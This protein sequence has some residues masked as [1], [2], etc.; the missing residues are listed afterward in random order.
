MRLCGQ[1]L[2][3]DN[4]AVHVLGADS[5]LGAGAAR[6]T[7]LP[8]AN[9]RP[10][11]SSATQIPEPASAATAAA[12]STGTG[13]AAQ[14]AV[15][16]SFMTHAVHSPEV[17]RRGRQDGSAAAAAALLPWHDHMGALN[18]PY[19]R[20]LTQRAISMVIRNPGTRTMPWK[21]ITE[22]VHERF[23]SRAFCRMCIIVHNDACSDAGFQHCLLWHFPSAC[24][25]IY[26]AE[27]IQVIKQ[28]SGYQTNAATPAVQV[29]K[30]SCWSVSWMQCCRTTRGCYWRNCCGKGCCT[31]ARPWW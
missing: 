31:C 25:R 30:R 12:V 16:D 29:L 19:W 7:P 4:G 18:E 26:S 10:G 20:G 13:N 14:P 17:V 1:K 3:S 24:H 27:N 28:L 2:A 22:K 5:T 8:A 9:L 21:A 15:G 6:K 11:F 23:G